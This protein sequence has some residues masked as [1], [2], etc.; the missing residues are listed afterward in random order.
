MKNSEC[1]SS[2]ELDIEYVQ[3]VQAVFTSW[4]SQPQFAHSQHFSRRI[5][6]SYP[7]LGR[8]ALKDL[9]CVLNSV[10]PHYQ[11]ISL[12]PQKREPRSKGQHLTNLAPFSRAN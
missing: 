11:S 7:R 6:L 3:L 12:K 1:V 9:E 2:D 4:F 10:E 8:E 5:L